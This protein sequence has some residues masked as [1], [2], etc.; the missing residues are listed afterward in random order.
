MHFSKK[1]N[2]TPCPTIMLYNQPIDQKLMFDEKLNWHKHICT[3][4]S[5]SLKRLSII[6]M[7]AH[8]SWGAHRKSLWNIYR[9]LVVTK[10]ENGSVCYGSVF[11]SALKSLKTIHN[12]GIRFLFG[13]Y[14]TSPIESILREIYNQ[15]S[16]KKMVT[17]FSMPRITQDLWN[18]D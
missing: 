5:H 13:A 8:T 6:K 7:L 16:C 12:S 9:A 18:L 2:K 11:L 4:K 17:F 1:Y 15:P 10:I 3:I 14:V